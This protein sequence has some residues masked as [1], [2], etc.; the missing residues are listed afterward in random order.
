MSSSTSSRKIPPDSAVTPLGA[1][2]SSIFPFQMACSVYPQT[3]CFGSLFFLLLFI[4]YYFYL[5]SGVCVG[6]NV[7]CGYTRGGMCDCVY[8]YE[9]ERELRVLSGV[10]VGP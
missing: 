3:K 10:R 6:T 5:L 2:G 7:Y 4:M 1:P 8:M 9:K